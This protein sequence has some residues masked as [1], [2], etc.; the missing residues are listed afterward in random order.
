MIYTSSCFP[1]ECEGCDQGQ[2]IELQGSGVPASAPPYCRC[3]DG[4]GGKKC[5]EDLS[6]KYCAAAERHNLLQEKEYLVE[7]N[8]RIISCSYYNSFSPS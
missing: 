4:F 2:C 3:F 8:I 1:A 6:R 7:C 5:D